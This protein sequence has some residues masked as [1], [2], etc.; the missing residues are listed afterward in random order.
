MQEQVNSVN[1]LGDLDAQR[2]V[3][4]QY[5]VHTVCAV[6][7]MDLICH[8]LG[9]ADLVRTVYRSCLTDEDVPCILA[10]LGTSARVPK[11]RR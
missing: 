9:I 11:E 7:T 2:I 4:T 8:P 6:A 1:W 3:Y 5:V 10:A